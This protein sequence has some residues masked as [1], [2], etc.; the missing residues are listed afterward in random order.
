VFEQ[1]LR[2]GVII[3]T[4][5]VFGAPSCVRITIGTETQNRQVLEALSQVLAVTP[6]LSASA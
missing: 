2:R 4:G 3:R 6:T 1:L 5:D